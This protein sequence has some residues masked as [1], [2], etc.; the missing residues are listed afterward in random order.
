[1]AATNKKTEKLL[2]K[3]KVVTSDQTEMAKLMASFQELV[4]K[5]DADAQNFLD[6]LEKKH[7]CPI[8]QEFPKDPVKI[9]TRDA[10][11]SISIEF[12]IYERTAIEEWRNERN[13]SPAT[14]NTILAVIGPQ[15]SPEQ[16][17]TFCED[18]CTEI[19]GFF[20]KKNIKTRRLT[21][22]PQNHNL[23]NPQHH[24]F[25][26]NTQRRFFIMNPQHRLV[27]ILLNLY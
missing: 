24:L 26:L 1:M 22:A 4:D 21:A 27:H 9:R 25:I 16:F 11:G 3:L 19:R 15:D 2:A 10:S 7:S 5:E 17:K 8:T 18:I 23:L 12:Q 6:N 20:S 14:R 13:T